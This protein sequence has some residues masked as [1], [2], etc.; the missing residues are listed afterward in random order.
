MN[1]PAVIK[2]SGDI[3][4]FD[5]SKLVQCLH[6]IYLR[7]QGGRLRHPRRSALEAWEVQRIEKI[8]VSLLDSLLRQN[9]EIIHVEEIQERLEAALLT[10]GEHAI[11][12]AM[13]MYRRRRDSIRV[14]PPEEVDWT[15]LST[16]LCADF[17]PL[18]DVR[19]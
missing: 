5:V 15:P 6:R 13:V 1:T 19:E 14:K 11:S 3:V 17:F 9:L 16:G 4:A 10:A 8:V 18:Q 7:D 12:R 2:R